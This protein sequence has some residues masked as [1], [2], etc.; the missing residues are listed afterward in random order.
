M[1]KGPRRKGGME[2]ITAARSPGKNFNVDMIHPAECLTELWRSVPQ[3]R[4]LKTRFFNEKWW[5][6]STDL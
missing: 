5:G 2:F 6:I 1:R 3:L 4:H